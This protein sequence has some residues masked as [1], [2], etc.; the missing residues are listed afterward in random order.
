MRTLL[1]TLATVMFGLFTLHAQEA[2]AVPANGFDRPL[3]VR[4]LLTAGMGY[5]QIAVLDDDAPSAP[6]VRSW[7]V[8]AGLEI[9]VTASFAVRTEVGYT[10]GGGMLDESLGGSYV[11]REEYRFSELRIPVLLQVGTSARALTRGYL[12]LGGVGGY[13]VEHSWRESLTSTNHDGQIAVT[14][15]EPVD[16]LVPL[17]VGAVVEAGVRTTIV[18]LDLGCDVRLHHGL[19]SIGSGSHVVVPRD[20]TFSIGIAIP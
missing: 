2:D 18:G 10:N 7:S 19:T 8:R 14:P 12:A 5:G 15:W 1:L 11:R 3:P 4:F 16:G 9:P 6:L 17:Y 20:V 13:I